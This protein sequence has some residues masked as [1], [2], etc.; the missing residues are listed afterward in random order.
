M[1]QSLCDIVL[2]EWI[3][4]QISKTQT[5]REFAKAML[6]AEEYRAAH[7]LPSPDDHIPTDIAD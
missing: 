5:G 2:S 1:A 6:K 7:P 3:G 4:K